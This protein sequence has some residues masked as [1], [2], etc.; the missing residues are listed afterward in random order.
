[1]PP[2]PYRLNPSELAR[3]RRHY[4]VNDEDGCWIWSGPKLPNG[5]AK[6]RRGPG[7]SDRVVHRILYEHY[8]ST[9]IPEGMQLDHLCRRRE[10]VNPDHFEVVTPSENTRR[11]DHA[12]RN[13]THCPHGHEYPYH[14]AGE[15]PVPCLRP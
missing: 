2:A 3:I 14:E 7:H 9:L 5:Y 10:C 8:K 13:K 6:W 11:Q 15:T 1:M 12:Y 4:L